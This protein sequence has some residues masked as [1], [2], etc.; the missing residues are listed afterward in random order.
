MSVHYPRAKKRIQQG[1]FTRAWREIDYILD[2]VPNH[3]Q[4]LRTSMLLARLS[5]SHNKAFMYLKRAIQ[6][7]PRIPEI[8]I[9]CGDYF[10]TLGQPSSALKQY[11]AAVK[12]SNSRQ[13]KA[14]AHYK[15]GLVLFKMN[16]LQK[17]KQHAQKAYS[18]GISH[19]ELRKKLKAAG[20]WN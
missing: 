19:P 1:D 14:V 2:R 4:V 11:N 17:A 8:R 10:D 18:F 9:I 7:T 3:P 13:G 6:F 12:L 16:Q 5:G 15:A 20:A